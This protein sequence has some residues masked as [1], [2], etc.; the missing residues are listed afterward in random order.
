MH[1]RSCDYLFFSTV[2]LENE[3]KTDYE[4]SAKIALNPVGTENEKFIRFRS[5]ARRLLHKFEFYRRFLTSLNA[6]NRTS[7]ELKIMIT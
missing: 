4:S 7:V 3:K 2:L 6:A 5:A 1:L